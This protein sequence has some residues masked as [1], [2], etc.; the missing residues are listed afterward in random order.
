MTHQQTAAVHSSTRASLPLDS[1]P[2]SGIERE[3]FVDYRAKLRQGV[4]LGFWIYL[5][6]TATDYL[7][8]QVNSVA[9]WEVFRVRLVVQILLI[10]LIWTIREKDLT[11]KQFRFA[12]TLTYTVASAGVTLMCIPTGGLTSLYFAGV[13]LV[14]LAR[15]VFVSEH[16]RK[17]LP[18]TVTII[19]PY[20]GILLMGAVFDARLSSQL[21]DRNAIFL[22]LMQ[23]SFIICVGV[24]A[25]WA[26]HS[27]WALRRK[28]YE[29]RALGRYRLE[30]KIGVGGMG[31]VWSAVH[32]RLRRRVAIKILRAAPEGDE[33][34]RRFEREFAAT[35]ALSHPNTVRVF[36]YGVTED[37]ILYYVMELLDGEPL[38]SLLRREG[39]LPTSRA[40]YLVDQA[41]RALGEAHQAGICH[42]DVKPDNLYLTFCGEDGD[43]IKVLD[44]GVAKEYQRDVTIRVTQTGAVIG[45]PEYMSPEV[46]RGGSADARADV[47]ALGVVLYHCVTGQTPFEGERAGALMFSHINTQPPAPSKLSPSVPKDLERVIL[48]CLS[49]K[50]AERYA[51]GMALSMALSLCGDYGKWRPTPQSSRVALSPVGTKDEEEPLFPTLRDSRNPGSVSE[52]VGLVSSGGAQLFTP[53]P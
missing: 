3:E 31:E 15:S 41:A 10:P 47:Y 46:A 22:F 49:K 14:L 12:E 34:V 6:F 25:A 5:C 7:I 26:G 16:W 21:S 2:G 9:F 11:K 43:F 48:R 20:P 1:N 52:E 23:L 32:P 29:S 19:L 35:S 28:V 42:R 44:F 38:S 36:D 13:M 18:T 33:A 39:A 40:V 53:D 30:R 8:A 24:L 45:T 17:T 37:G 51:D 27:V 4:T 50:P